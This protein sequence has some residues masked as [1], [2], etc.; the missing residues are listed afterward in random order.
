MSSEASPGRRGPGPG[1]A[2]G[3]VAALLAATFCFVGCVAEISALGREHEAPVAA[4]IAAAAAFAVA[5]LVLVRVAIRLEHRFRSGQPG[6]R[7][8]ASAARRAPARHPRNGPASRIAGAVII[9]GAVAALTAL[10]V[11]LHSQASLS[12]YT[13]RHGLARAAKVEAVHP[14]SHDTS[15]D[16][17]TTYDYGV[18]LA[19]PAGAVTRTVA[20]DPTR[21][22]QRFDP[23]DTIRV[24]VDPRQP[25]Y[26]ELPGIPVGTSS[27][28]IG[29][30]TLAVIFLGLLAL[31]TAEEIRH[32]R[33]RPAAVTVS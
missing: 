14:V 20:H 22:F 12:S 3:A 23:G 33:L 27:W 2:L 1:A 24:L 15:H 26:A 32:R 8:P 9:V 13:Q 11:S 31:I 7:A 18:V 16:S 19:V 10:A 25:G 17:W 6:V 28:F 30:L 4:L 29:P 5:A 21:D